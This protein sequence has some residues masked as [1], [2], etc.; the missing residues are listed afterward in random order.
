MLAALFGKKPAPAPAPA[1]SGP[2]PPVDKNASVLVKINALKE[3]KE[4]QNKR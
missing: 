3:Q 4:T 1:P 2:T